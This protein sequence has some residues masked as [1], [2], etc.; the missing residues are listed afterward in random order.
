MREDRIR[1]SNSSAY[2]IHKF[3]NILPDISW[4]SFS[5]YIFWISFPLIWLSAIA[6][7]CFTGKHENSFAAF[8]K[9]FI[10]FVFFAIQNFP[11]FTRR[12]NVLK[13]GYLVTLK[14]SWLEYRNFWLL[15]IR[16]LWCSSIVLVKRVNFWYF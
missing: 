4:P 10:R 15:Y 2:K 12:I 6:R 3:K 5:H 11:V 8:V 1:K 7:T 16:L 9:T 14:S 13:L